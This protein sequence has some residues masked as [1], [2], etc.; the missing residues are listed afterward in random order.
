MNYASQS[1]KQA[2]DTG[3]ITRPVE[4]S[5]PPQKLQVLD[6]LLQRMS[7]ANSRFADQLSGFD[8]LNNRLT[9]SIPESKQDG[10]GPGSGS[11]V[12]GALEYQIMCYEMMLGRMSKELERLSQL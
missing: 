1:A 6:H 11:S 4:L 8:N 5:P 7:E 12:V 10:A 2:I 3:R 9:G